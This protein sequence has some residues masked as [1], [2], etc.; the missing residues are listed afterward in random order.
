MQEKQNLVYGV[1]VTILAY[2]FFAIASA[3][4][5]AIDPSFPAVEILFFQNFIC[6]LCVI[7][8]CFK[9]GIAHLKTSHYFLHLTRDVS[10]VLSYFFYFLAI[11]YIDLVDATALS[12]TAPFYTPWVWMIWKKEKVNKH[13]WWTIILGF[14][15]IAL[16]LKP[17]KAIF[18]QLGSLV[19]IVSGMLS[20]LALVAVRI[21]N[22]QKESLLRTLFYYFLVGTLISLPFCIM[23]FVMPTKE[24]FLLLLG[25][26]LCIALGQVFL[27]SAYHHGTA[28]FL[29]PLSYST[30]IFT[31][32]IS[33]I[34]FHIFP[35]LI[36]IAGIILIIFGGSLTY[37]LTKKKPSMTNIL[38][39]N[40]HPSWWTKLYRRK[41]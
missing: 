7:P 29:S 17:G 12:Y 27:T 33:C 9:E 37:V 35:D 13:V 16:V 20:A 21:I 11:Q 5:K 1:S 39:A 28:S 2:F 10:G 41:K 6:L 14:I 4:V 15:G 32:L 40:N 8:Y 25:V 18:Y 23:Q 19:A 34:I 30:V 36:S 26:G 24:E 31:T 38:E 22:Q 3:F